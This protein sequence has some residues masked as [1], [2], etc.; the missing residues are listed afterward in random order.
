MVWI[1]CRYVPQLFDSL[2]SIAKP[3]VR[4]STQEQRLNAISFFEIIIE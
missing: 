3:V 2:V 4:Q 1:C